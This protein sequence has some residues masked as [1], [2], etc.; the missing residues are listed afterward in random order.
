MIQ[1]KTIYKYAGPIYRFENII[2]SKWE[3][4]TMAVSPQQALNNLTYRAKMEL[5]YDRQSKLTLDKKCLME[6]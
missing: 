1:K 5:K 2:M 6:V 3:A 4:V